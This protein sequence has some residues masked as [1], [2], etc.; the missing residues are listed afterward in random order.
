MVPGQNVLKLKIC[1]V[2]KDKIMSAKH[3]QMAGVIRIEFSFYCN[4]H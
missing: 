4:G 3:R 1:N 2:A